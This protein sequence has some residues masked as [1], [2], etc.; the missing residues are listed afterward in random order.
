MV[1]LADTTFADQYDYMSLKLSAIMCEAASDND[2]VR[3]FGNGAAVSPI[4]QEVVW[5]ESR[6][7]LI[8]RAP[9]DCPI[10]IETP[11]SRTEAGFLAC[12][13]CVNAR[14]IIEVE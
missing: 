13:G 3:D 8:S 10:K 2:V 5:D 11:G 1:K 4:G 6:V 12:S 14:F 7:D 9:E